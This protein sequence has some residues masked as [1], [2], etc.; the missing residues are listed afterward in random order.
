LEATTNA[1]TFLHQ[2]VKYKWI[3][4]ATT[5]CN[6]IDNIFEKIKNVDN[7]K[8]LFL[9]GWMLNNINKTWCNFATKVPHQTM[10]ND[11]LVVVVMLVPMLLKITTITY[12]ISM[13][14]SYIIFWI[15][16][17]TTP[18]IVFTESLCFK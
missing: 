8:A 15:I 12:N 4:C 5:I 17:N 6:Q 18:H 13:A 3:Y 10:E 16:F 1:N 9:C 2:Q 14:K 11:E 7:C